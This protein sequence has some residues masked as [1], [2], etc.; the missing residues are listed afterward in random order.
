[1]NRNSVIAAVVLVLLT[2][3]CAGSGSHPSSDARGSGGT[4][5]TSARLLAYSNCMRSHG[6]P[7][8]PDPDSS[9]QIPQTQLKNLRVSVSVVRAANS[10]C[11]HLI[12]AQPGINEP[13]SAQQQHEYLRA[14]AC[15]RAH[16]LPNFPNPT[17]SGNQ[18]QFP[19]PPGIDTNAPQFRRARQVC[20]RLIPA[21][22]P[23]SGNSQ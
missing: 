7:N 2:A 18:V 3:A 17:F 13:F 15:M 6:V 10:H 12:P 5:S 22:L 14:A 9:G 4:R 20:S 16:A 23:Y 21:G 11:D 19:I 8:Y 1:M